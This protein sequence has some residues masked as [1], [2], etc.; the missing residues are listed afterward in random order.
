MAGSSERV[1][2]P[3]QTCMAQRVTGMPCRTIDNRARYRVPQNRSRRLTADLRGLR[4][5]RP[6]GKI[7]LPECIIPMD[8]ELINYEVLHGNLPS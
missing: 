3:Q 7:R 6:P 1:S 8:G 5:C 4:L 2:L